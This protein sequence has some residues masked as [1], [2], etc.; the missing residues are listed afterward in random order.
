MLQIKYKNNWYDF[1]FHGIKIF[2]VNYTTNFIKSIIVDNDEESKLI[3]D[4]KNIKWKNVIYINE[5]SKIDNFLSLNK[6]NFLYKEIIETI[7]DNLLINEQLINKIANQI[8]LNLGINNLL[9]TQ[10]DVSKLISAC[11]EMINL[12]FIDE[13]T[14]FNLLNKLNF[15]ERKLIIFDNVSFAT[16]KNCK[17]LLN[18]FNILIICSDLRGIVE[19]IKELELCCLENHYLFEIINIEKVISFLELKT[20]LIINEYDL[21]NYLNKKNDQKSSLIHFY[22]KSI[23][24]FS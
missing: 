19:N 5:M 9:S 17:K 20:S 22:L 21:N 11:F 13:T 15:D 10:Y 1:E 4:G 12:G 7:G 3:I 18:N 6:S 8:N 24:N 2:E 14:I 16:Y 23:V